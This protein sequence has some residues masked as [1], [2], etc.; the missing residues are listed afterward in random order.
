MASTDTT[1]QKVALVTGAS[2]G[3]GAATARELARRGCALVLA[4][5]SEDDLTR[6]AGDLTR[7]GTPALPVATDM[8]DVDQ[9]SRLADA[10]LTRFGRVDV[11]VHNAGIGDKNR[12]LFEESDPAYTRRMLDVNLANPIALTR[13]LLPQMLERRRGSIVF[14]ASVAGHIS[15]PMSTIY[16]ATKSGLRGFAGSLRRELLSTGVNVSVIAPGFIDTAMTANLRPLP[17]PGPE[18]VAR[19]IAD[20]VEQP[21]REVVTPGFYQLGIAI[22]RWF[23]AL[24]DLAVRPLVRGARR[25]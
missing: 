9:V 25:R 2:R 15:L 6:L 12:R 5:R 10:A 16:S 22:E 11:I 4:A 24:V 7:R 18:S 8:A 23:P 14:V 21:R 3:I 13:R 1:P 20:L 17:M 19:K